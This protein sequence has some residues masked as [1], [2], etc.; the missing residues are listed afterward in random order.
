MNICSLD[1]LVVD[2]L[3]PVFILKNGLPPEGVGN[4]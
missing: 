4:F 1:S 2:V 3:I